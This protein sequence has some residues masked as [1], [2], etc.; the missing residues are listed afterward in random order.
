LMQLF[1]NLTENALRHTP[2]GST[3]SIVASR[4]T[5]NLTVSVVDNGPG[6]PENMREKVLQRFF[7]LEVSRTTAGNGLGL[8]LANA[9]V[10]VHDAKLELADAAP[11]LR[12]SVIF[13][14]S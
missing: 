4:S 3:I 10:H 13:T 5:G 8:S 7:R 1:A 2:R 6:I 14:A 9:I 11:G 12:A